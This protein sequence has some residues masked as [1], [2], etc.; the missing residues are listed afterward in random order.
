MLGTCGDVGGHWG[1]WGGTEDAGR[2]L[3]NGDASGTPGAGGR[4]WGDTRRWA[5]TLGG[6][7]GHRRRCGRREDTGETGTPRGDTWAVPSPTDTPGCPQGAPGIAGAPGFPG[8]RGPPGPQGAT[9]PLGPKGQTVR[10]PP[11]APLEGEWGAG[12][13]HCHQAPPTGPAHSRMPRPDLSQSPS[14]SPWRG[15]SPVTPGSVPGPRVLVPKGAT[16]VGRGGVGTGT[17]TGTG[18]DWEGD[19]DEGGV[20]LGGVGWGQGQGQVRTGRGMGMRGGGG[21]EWS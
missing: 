3:G 7:G 21:Q 14:P 9:G 2:T 18:K 11:G 6:C 16:G 10:A 13:A 5:R 19:G 17:G 4:R 20:G 1:C 15:P 8:P 12:P